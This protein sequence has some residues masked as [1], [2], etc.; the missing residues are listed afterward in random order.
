MY[1]A[2][3]DAHLLNVSEDIKDIFIH[4]FTSSMI[5]MVKLFLGTHLSLLWGKTFYNET[6]LGSLLGDLISLKGKPSCE[7]SL[8]S[9]SLV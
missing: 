4:T 5:C 9:L 7:R 3:V 1:P 6:I 8:C 2:Y